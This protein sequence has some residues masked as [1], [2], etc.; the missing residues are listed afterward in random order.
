MAVSSTVGN[1]AALAFTSAMALLSWGG[2]LEAIERHA[3]A[4]PSQLF[5][6][7]GACIACH[8]QLTAPSGEDVSIGSAWRATMMANS[9]RDPYWQASMRR[10]LLEHAPAAA[11]IENECSTCHMPMMNAEARAAGGQGEVFAN[12]PVGANATRPAMLAADGVSCTVCHQITDD[13]FGDPASFNGHFQVDTSRAWD[14]RPVYGRHQ[15]DSGRAAIMH[16]SS[17]FVPTQGLHVRR[18]E[19]CATCHTLYTTALDAAGNAIGRLPEQMP[20]LE[21]QH[22][23]FA[24]TTSCQD[25]HMPVVTDSMPISGVWGQKRPGLARHDF[26]GGNFFMLDR[27][28]DVV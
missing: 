27:S 9:A 2:A 6:T 25:C 22:S 28:E 3:A 11:A 17:A 10:E 24:T 26:L 7:S 1:A 4:P 14:T 12:L 21:W 20:Y 23:R 19:L 16:S 5:E 15:I 18:S 13:N 8:N